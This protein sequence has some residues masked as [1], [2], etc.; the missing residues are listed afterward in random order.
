[1]PLFTVVYN[2]IDPIQFPGASVSSAFPPGT[3]VEELQ[4]VAKW[5]NFYDPDDILGYPLKGLSASYD[6]TVTEDISVNVGGITAMWNP[7]SH[8]EYWTDNSFTI[9]VTDM[10]SDILD[11]L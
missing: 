7:A 5:L 2:K 10:L 11:L 9:P 8:S 3:S 1:M 6:K 4:K